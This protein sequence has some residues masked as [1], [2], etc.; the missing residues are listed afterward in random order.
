MSVY[1]IAEIGVNHNGDIGC[2]KRL[3][4][5]AALSGCDAVKFQVFRARSLVTKDA[6]QAEYQKRNLKSQDVTQYEMLKK[7]ELSRDDFY[8]LKQYCESSGID[9]LATPFDDG[10]VGDLEK[11]EVPCYKIGSGDITNMPLLNC[12]ARTGK[13]VIL[14][15]G[16]SN[17]GE[18]EEAINWLQKAGSGDITLLHCTS[19]YPTAYYEVNMLAMKTLKQRFDLPVGYSD[20]TIGSEISVMAV[21]MGATIIEKHITLDRDMEGPDHAAS[22]ETKDLPALVDAIRHV[23]EAFGSGEKARQACEEGTAIAARKSL[24]SSR[25]I[26]KGTVISDVDMAVK[27]P[28]LGIPPK[29]LESLIGKVSTRDIKA[30]ELLSY[31]DLMDQ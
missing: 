8:Y 27:R 12:V 9:F 26:P 30:D 21:A 4:D 15:T 7:L 3:I 1:V 25:A 11:L 22:L 13:P 10:S 14:S 28:G 19:N 20:H 17:L 18:I 31:K 5:A 2:A 16:M 23:E 24:V 6:E 29:M